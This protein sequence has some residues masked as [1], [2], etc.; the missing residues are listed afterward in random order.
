MSSEWLRS[1]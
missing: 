1:I